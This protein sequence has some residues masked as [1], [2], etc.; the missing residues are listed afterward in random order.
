MQTQ[1]KDKEDL[2]LIITET[3]VP[4]MKFKTPQLVINDSANTLTKLAEEMRLQYK[5]PVVA[6]TRSM[7][8]VQ[9]EC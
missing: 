4:D 6:I 3:Y 7:G 2:G 8:K 9:L 1:K 5:H